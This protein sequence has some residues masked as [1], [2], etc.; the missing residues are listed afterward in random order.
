MTDI[1]TDYSSLAST[2]SIF[3][4]KILLLIRLREPYFYRLFL[5]RR[6]PAS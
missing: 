3:N 2:E 4:L 6:K 5:W 1:K